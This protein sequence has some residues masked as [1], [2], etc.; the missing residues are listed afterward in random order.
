VPFIDF[1][2]DNGYKKQYS[3]NFWDNFYKIPILYERAT[4][5]N[6]ALE[7]I[8]YLSKKYNICY[9]TSRPKEIE[10]VTRYWMRSYKFPNYESLYF[11]ENKTIEIRKYK[12]LYFIED[13]WIQNKVDEM[14]KLTNIILVDRIYNKHITGVPRIYN[15]RE[16]KELL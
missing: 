13:Q 3:E 11:S 15:L 16:L 6:G 4:P 8:E 9:I 2:S 12:C 5:I 1:W 14:N 7:T 10:F